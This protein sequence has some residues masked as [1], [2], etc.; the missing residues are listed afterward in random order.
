MIEGTSVFIPASEQG[1]LTA[2]LESLERVLALDPDRILPAHG[3][4]IEEPSKILRGY[5]AHRMQREAQIVAA[6]RGG[7]T[8]VDMLVARMYPDLNAPLLP[9]AGDTVTAHLVKL[10]R[11]G[12]A[13]RRGDAWHIIES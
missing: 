2:Y 6:L 12:R 7:D 3:P 1:D 5:I 10:E 8:L 4:V 9:R 11:D 13:G